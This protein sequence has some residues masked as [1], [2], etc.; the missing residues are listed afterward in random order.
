M[1]VTRA[2]IG[3]IAGYAFGWIGFAIGIA[4]MTGIGGTHTVQVLS[5]QFI[6]FLMNGEVRQW[7]LLLVPAAAG[8]VLSQ[9][10][11]AFQ[12]VC[13]AA[14]GFLEGIAIGNALYIR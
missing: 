12:V 2:F 13:G 4:I 10:P 6:M 5:P 7:R 3:A 8:A 14:V 1:I 9:T 11:L